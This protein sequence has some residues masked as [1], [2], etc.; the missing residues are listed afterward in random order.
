MIVTIRQHEAFAVDEGINGTVNGDVNGTDGGVSEQVNSSNG[1]INVLDK[2]VD[3]IFEGIN[4]GINE[5]IKRQELIKI[6]IKKRPH[7]TTD[8]LAGL[9]NVSIATIEREIKI[10]KKRQ[11]KRVGSKKSGYW[12]VIE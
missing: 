6:A 2:S 11:I 8:Q 4:E 3:G 7:I 9:L 10:M 1:G 5:G 12:E